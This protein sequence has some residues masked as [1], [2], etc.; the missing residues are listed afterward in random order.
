MKSVAEVFGRRVRAIRKK[1]SLT[2]ED[3]AKAAGMDA[4]HIGAIERGVKTSSFEAVGR[5]SAALGVQYYELFLPEHRA[6]EDVEKEIADLLHGVKPI[7]DSNIA[8][9]LRGLRSA[10]RKL[11]GKVAG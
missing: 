10:L 1:R 3:L 8:E 5:L 2:Q 7:D 11:S 6:S 9:F 4:K